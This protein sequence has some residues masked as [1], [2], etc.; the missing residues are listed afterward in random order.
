MKIVVAYATPERQVELPI[1]VSAHCTVA[2]AIRQSGILQEFPELA[3]ESIT[4][5]IFGQ[6]VTLETLLNEGERVEIYRPL[7]IDP[8]EAR[9]NRVTKKPKP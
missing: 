7:R 1:A 4:V 6:R 3:L 5:G 2:W 9:R 8:R